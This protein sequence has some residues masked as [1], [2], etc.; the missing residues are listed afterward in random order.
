MTESFSENI[1]FAEAFEFLFKNASDTIYILDKHGRFVAANRKSEELTGYELKDFV[2]KSFRKVVSAKSLPKAIKGFLNVTRRKTIRIELE[3]KTSTNKKIPVEVISLPLI[4]DDKVIGC[5]GIVRDITESRNIAALNSFARKLS[6]INNL[7]Q[8]YE[9]TLDAM[10]RTLGFEHATFM[11]IDESNLR[12]ARQRG[13]PSSLHLEL[14]L[15]GTKKGVT[16]RAANTHKPILVFDT[17][18]NKDYVEGVPGIRSELAVPVVTEDKILGVL[19]VESRKLEAFNP[20][21]MTLLQILASHAATVISNLEKRR[22]IEKRSSQL[23]SLMNASTRMMSSTD[24]RQRLQTVAEAIKELGWRRVVISVRDENLEI[25]DLVTE[26]LTKNEIKLLLERKSPGNVWRE[27][28]GPRYNQFRIGEFYYL[29]WSDSWVRENVHG[30]PASV[31]IEKATTYSGIPSK[32]ALD[33][34]VDWHPQDMLYAPLRLLEGRIVGVISMDDP[35][36]GRRPTMD[37]LMPLR[38]FLYQAAVAIENAQLIQQLD[39][40]K[41]KVKEYADQLELKVKQRTKEL[42]EAQ[43]RLIK[44]ERLA[45]IGEVAAMVGHDLRNPL[46]SI[47]GATYYVKTKFSPKTDQKTIEMLELIEKGVEYSNK[48]V[49]DLLAYSGEIRL[50]LLETTPKSAT[51]DVLTLVKI[52]ENIRILDLTEDEPKIKVDVEKM[53]RVFAN[54]IRNAIDSMPEGGI[55]TITSKTS[56][57]SIAIVFSDTGTGMPKDISEKIWVPFFTTKAKGMGLGLPICKRI[58]EA[59]N[60]KILVESKIG[61][62][63]T[64]MV[65]LPIKPKIG[66]GEEKWQNMPES[67]LLTTTKA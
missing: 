60:G 48:I 56:G 26:G 23:T 52:P 55:L 18:K 67:L 51:E 8:V 62:G 28:F 45:A 65:T 32:L 7:Q 37:S 58:V 27:R 6:T 4:G 29:P 20:K 30:V 38:L 21:D 44:S 41:N 36:N 61:K 16:V 19:N 54:I 25:T 10:E 3:L 66:G 22:E 12:V 13:Y 14:P 15:D 43:E 34:M 24:L 46:T 5:L 40:A 50:E 64:F 63:T 47:G 39:N 35:S 57:D 49:N 1:S 9:L 53:K 59:H 17:E 42:M 2:G 11:I 31:P 33:E